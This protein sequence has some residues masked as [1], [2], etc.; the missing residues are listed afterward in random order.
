M[1][2]S[3]NGGDFVGAPE[4]RLGRRAE[5]TTAR[6]LRDRGWLV[7]EQ[8][9]RSAAGEIDLVCLDPD[10]ILVGVEVKLRRTSRAGEPAEAVSG[11]RLRRLRRALADYA[12]RHRQASS[13]LRIDLVALTPAGHAWRLAHWPGVDAW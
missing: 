7:L 4:Q 10:G 2:A 13:G 5:A 6:W 3:L 9:W 1:L 8:R 12:S 11:Q